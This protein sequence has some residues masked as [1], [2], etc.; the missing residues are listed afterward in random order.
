MDVPTPCRHLRMVHQPIYG[1]GSAGPV[2][3]RTVPHCAR[4]G[5][6]RG[7]DGA[8]ALP[9]DSRSNIGFSRPCNA[10]RGCYE[11]PEDP[12]ED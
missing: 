1:I 4:T 11:A 5:G 10:A 3:S 2:T 7:P 12:E 9:P 6:S 8:F